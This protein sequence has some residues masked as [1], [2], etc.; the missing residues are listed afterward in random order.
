MYKALSR[1]S[2]ICSA[3]IDMGMGPISGYLCLAPIAPVKRLLR[4]S[5]CTDKKRL[6]IGL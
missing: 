1:L 4:V 3:I 2:C 5:V 6:G